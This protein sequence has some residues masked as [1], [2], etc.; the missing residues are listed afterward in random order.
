MRWVAMAWLLV[1]GTSYAWVWGWANFLHLCDIAV[2]LTCVGLWRGSSLAD[3][4]AS[5]V[6]DCS[7]SV[8]GCGLC[9][10]VVQRKTS[11]R[12]NRIHVGCPLSVG[13]ASAFSLSCCLAGVADLGTC[14]S[15]IRQARVALANGI[16][17]RRAC[18][19]AL[20]APEA[21]LNF[22]WRDPF[23]HQALGPAWLHLVIT[24]SALVVCVYWPT[25]WILGRLFPAASS[26]SG[27][28]Q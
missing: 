6:I 18:L 15:E 13:R 17:R 12:W 5:V 8:L 2:I 7:S 28:P 24:A 10:A 21:N 19:V 27:K 26:G 4:H 11:H 25:H 14:E 23:L 16:C 3:F 20:P 1:W 22:A 9:L